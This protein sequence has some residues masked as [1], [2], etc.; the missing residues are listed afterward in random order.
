MYSVGLRDFLSY[1]HEIVLICDGRLLSLLAG[2]DIRNFFREQVF[3][4]LGCT[5]HTIYQI[6][7][8]V[9][10]RLQDCRSGC[11]CI[12]SNCTDIIIQNKAVRVV[13]GSHIISWLK[14]YCV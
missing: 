7:L 9:W 2:F 5:W 8:F 10:L 3:A 13:N 14:I 6:F 1:Q 11:V 4:F 12:N